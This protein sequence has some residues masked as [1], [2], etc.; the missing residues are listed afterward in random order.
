[1]FLKNLLDTLG[2][3]GHSSDETETDDYT[4]QTVYRVKVM[5]LATRLVEVFQDDRRAEE[6]RKYLLRERV[7]GC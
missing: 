2:T 3:E 5:F 1:M 6:R 4:L 7:E